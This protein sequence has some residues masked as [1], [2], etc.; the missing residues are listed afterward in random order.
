MVLNYKYRI[1]P[2]NTSII[3]NYIFEYNQ[4][5]NIALSLIQTQG[6]E[7]YDAGVKG[8]L[9]F[10]SLYEKT[11]SALKSRDIHDKSALTQDA[12]RSAYGTLF[13]CIKKKV[14]F[15]L[16]YKKS[17]S[18][19]G[20]F[21]FRT[22]ELRNKVFSSK[23]KTIMHREIPKGYRILGAKIKREN[24]RYYIIYSVTDDLKKPKP[25]KG[26]TD[27]VG[28]DANQGNYTF[29][30]GYTL[31]FVKSIYPNLEK[32]RKKAQQTLSSKKK[33]SNNRKKKQRLLFNISRKI[34]NHR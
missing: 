27:L 16:H 9:I 5:Y 4:A 25:K 3:D 19:E 30:S 34:K 26:E 29:S 20:S 15:E 1:Y 6:R 14:P 17:S 13:T 28:M 24:T 21:I 11:R 33:R 32:K 8:N 22:K 18:L 10:K 12:L 7:Q 31:D 23:F 2:E